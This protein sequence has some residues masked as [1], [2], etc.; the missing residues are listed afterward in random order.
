MDSLD[1]SAIFAECAALISFGRGLVDPVF[2]PSEVL[3]RPDLLDGLC[4]GL[5]LDDAA[6]GYLSLTLRDSPADS[7]MTEQELREGERGTVEVEAGYL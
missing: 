4:W 1:S 5:Y 6:L 7:S 3:P 2:E